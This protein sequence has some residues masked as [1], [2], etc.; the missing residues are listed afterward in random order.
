MKCVMCD[1]SSNCHAGIVVF[2]INNNYRVCKKCLKFHKHEFETEFDEGM[3]EKSKTTQMRK[4]IQEKVDEKLNHYL[5]E[6]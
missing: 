5:L 6:V 4:Y 1:R 3:T 2:G